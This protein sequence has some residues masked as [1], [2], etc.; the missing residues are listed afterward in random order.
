MNQTKILL[1]DL[2]FIN[3]VTVSLF[4]LFLGF[5]LI[6][7]CSINPWSNLY[8][9]YPL[10]SPLHLPLVTLSSIPWL[11]SFPLVKLS[12][13]P[14]VTLSSIPLLPF[15]PSFGYILP[16][17]ICFT[18]VSSVSWFPCPFF[19]WL[20]SHPSLGVPLFHPLDALSSFLSV[21]QSSFHRFLPLFLPL[22]TFSSF[23]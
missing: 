9:S 18:T 8:L 16:F 2:F 4:L 12:K 21:T 20:P 7:F 13:F 5:S 15:S 3:P 14:L 23:P 22:I 1:N 6:L 10:S 11:P 17:F 19:H